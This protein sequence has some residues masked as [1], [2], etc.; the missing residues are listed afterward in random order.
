MYDKPE[1]KQERKYISIYQTLL[2]QVDNNLCERDDPDRILQLTWR[3]PRSMQLCLY[4]SIWG[5]MCYALMS[6][7]LLKLQ[8]LSSVTMGETKHFFTLSCGKMKSNNQK[9]SGMGGRV[10]SRTDKAS[11]KIFQKLT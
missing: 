5:R 1:I 9:S 7:L 11:L 6:P 4:R 10:I 2:A 8:K 3:S